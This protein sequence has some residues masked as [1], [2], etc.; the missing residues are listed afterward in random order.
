MSL[1][2]LPIAPT[3]SLNAKKNRESV[4]TNPRFAKKPVDFDI[5]LEQAMREAGLRM[6][7]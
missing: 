6:E 4:E 2:I 3:E 1:E 5:I 7:S